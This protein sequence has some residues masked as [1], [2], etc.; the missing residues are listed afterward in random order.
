MVKNTYVDNYSEKSNI[1]IKHLDLK[2]PWDTMEQKKPSLC[3]AVK[4]YQRWRK[5]FRKSFDSEGQ[6]KSVENLIKIYNQATIIM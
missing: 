2:K 1:I 5:D 6:E 4:S 3:K